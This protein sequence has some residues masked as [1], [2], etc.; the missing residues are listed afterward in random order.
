[1]YPGITEEISSK[2]GEKFGLKESVDFFIAYSPERVSPGEMGRS[3]EDVARIVGSNNKDVGRYMAS[4]YSKITT[5]G[6][7]YVGK[8]KKKVLGKNKGQK[9]SSHFRIHYYF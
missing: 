2:V 7:K 3:A 1:M 5:G 4:I 6:C 8:I 9:R